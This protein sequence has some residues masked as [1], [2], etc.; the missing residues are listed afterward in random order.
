MNKTDKADTETDSRT[1]AGDWIEEKA[2]GWAGKDI[3]GCYT[4]D[5]KAVVSEAELK[6]S[7]EAQLYGTR[8]T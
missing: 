3:H 6:A 1:V 2:A 8:N 5:P 7:C 4:T